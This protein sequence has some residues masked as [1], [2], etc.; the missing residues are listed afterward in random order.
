L[1]GKDLYNEEDLLTRMAEGEQEAF[2]LLYRRHWEAL[3]ISTVRVI[4]NK[5]DA[6]DI[7]QEVFASLWNRRTALNLTGPLGAYL[8]TSV[9]YKAI[10]YIEKN[11]TRRNYAQ[12]LGKTAETSSPPSAEILL[13]VKEVQQLVRATIENM[14]PKMQEVYRLSRQQHLSHKEIA[15]RLDISEETVKKHIQ[16]A[17]QLLKMAMGTTRL[18]LA[19]IFYYL[20]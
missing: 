19:A 10:N 6:E 8:Q 13:S 15:L 18:A 12:T 20:M 2:T 4:L 1:K 5:E 16:N 9:K 7:V 11:I 3:F 17:L 14:P